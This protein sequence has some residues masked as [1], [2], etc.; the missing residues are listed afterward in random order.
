MTTMKKHLIIACCFVALLATGCDPIS[1][2]SNIEVTESVS[3]KATEVDLTSDLLEGIWVDEN[4]F[5]CSYVDNVFTDFSG[6]FVE[7]CN[8]K[9][10]TLSGKDI[11]G[12]NISWEIT[13]F[14]DG[15]IEIY[16]I[17]AIRSESDKGRQYDL[18]LHE[19]LN[20]KWIQ[21]FDDYSEYSPESLTYE[22]DKSKFIIHTYNSPDDDISL[23]DNKLNYTF[24]NSSF[25]MHFDDKGLE[26]D[27]PL[28]EFTVHIRFENDSLILIQVYGEV[29][30][31]YRE[32]SKTAKEKASQL[33]DA[34]S[35]PVGN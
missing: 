21:F 11:D 33:N 32:G 20:G 34:S 16:D 28:E 7:D 14:D 18:D 13:A 29:I 25:A 12:K 6:K 24:K 30:T 23:V 27:E 2:E 15:S 10:N 9:G 5:V 3:N 4:G 19:K 31:L 8:I 1:F 35:I 26:I 17:R 22:F